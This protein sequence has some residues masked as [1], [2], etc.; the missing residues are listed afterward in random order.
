MILYKLSYLCVTLEINNYIM[1]KYVPSNDR[2]PFYIAY[3]VYS[4][5]NNI[6]NPRFKRTHFLR[7]E[8]PKNFYKTFKN[9]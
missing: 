7:W 4:I 6:R 5:C 9:C 8:N 1:Y 2:I 3:Y